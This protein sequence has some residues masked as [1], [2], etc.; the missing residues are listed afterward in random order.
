MSV[1]DVNR[2]N[3]EQ[4]IVE[5]FTKNGRPLHMVEDRAFKVL[6]QP[7]FDALCIS[8]NEHNAIE[9]IMEVSNRVKEEIIGEEKIDTATRTDSSVLGV[10]V[11]YIKNKPI[12][13][14]TLA[15]KEL[16]ASHTSGYLKSIVLQVLQDYKKWYFS[17]KESI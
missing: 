17:S 13:I 10:N 8:V 7:I 4:V 14:M 5:L 16:K 6:V 15:V 2:N 1:S 11:Q 12:E 3:I 9:K